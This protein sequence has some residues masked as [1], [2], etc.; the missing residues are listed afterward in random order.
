VRGTVLIVDDTDSV[1]AILQRQLSDLGYEVLEATGGTEALKVLETEE[2]QVALV[3]TD[4]K[5]P[6]MDGRQLATALA[7]RPVPP[8]VLFVSAYPAPEGVAGIFLQKPF[9]T[10]DLALAVRKALRS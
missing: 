9:T 7:H 1:R 3:I 2:T 6:N 10:V 5:M 4:L 8:R